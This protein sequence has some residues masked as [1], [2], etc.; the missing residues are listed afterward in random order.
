[1]IKVCVIGYGTIGKRVADAVLKQDDMELVGIADVV[2]DYKVKVAYSKGI[3][4]YVP[5]EKFEDFKS[6]GIG[7]QGTI[8]ELLDKVDVVVDAT[9]AGIGAR[10]K[11]TLYTDR[12]VKVIFQG[13]EKANIAD[14]S[15]SALANYSKAVG[16]RFVRVV[17]CN[18]TAILRVIAAYLNNGYKIEKV[19]VNIARRGADPHEYRR[20]PINDV[21]LDPPKIPSH[22]AEDVK[23]VLPDINIVTSAIAIPVTITHL[24]FVNITFKDGISR[25]E[26]L[27]TLY[28]TPRIM[29]F[30]SSYGF[31]SSAQVIEW[32]RDIGRHRADIPENIIFKDTV[33]VIDQNELMFLMAVHQESIVIPENIDAIR[34]VSGYTNMWSSIR[35]TDEALGLFMEGKVYG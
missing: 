23:S 24:H 11:S 8:E 5:K 3:K 6:A 31:R 9:P 20:G 17:S 29:L 30:E 22:H 16:K 7:P 28:R 2:P 10:N 13:G 1:M 4:V 19:R 32:A 26:A 33:S 18:T 12:K 25:D 14:V 21:I 27:E 35:K 15:F 34:A